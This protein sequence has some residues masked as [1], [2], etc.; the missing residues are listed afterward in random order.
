MVEWLE[1]LV[2][3][4]HSVRETVLKLYGTVEGG[5]K[6]GLGAGGDLTIK[7]DKVAED[8]V[9]ENLLERGLSFTLL[10]EEA[11]IRRFGA[12]PEEAYVILDP[13]DGSLNASRGLP[14]AATALA[15][16]KRLS[17]ESVE[18]AVVM[19]I[20]HGTIYTANK[21]GGSFKDGE[22]VKPS[23]RK[24]L[25][26]TLLGVDLCKYRDLQSFSKLMPILREVRH[27]RHL[28]ANALE[29][30]Y[31]SDGTIDVYIELVGRLRVLDLS[32]PYLIVT[33]AG[34]IITDDRGR[35][36]KSPIT[37]S[38]KAVLEKIR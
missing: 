36:L 22:P 30:C 13:L 35:S 8:V 9:V 37:A 6:L 18:A 2:E 26:D 25:E 31:V 34:G 29:L 14:F 4:A 19:D 7:M 5:E 21:G 32:S 38:K 11:G 10:S 33:E 15:Y 28:G 17:L 3:C 16:S 23:E 1:V 12:K 27:V 24:S 20:V